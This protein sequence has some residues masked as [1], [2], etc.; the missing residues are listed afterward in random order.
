MTRNGGSTREWTLTAN[1]SPLI[2]VLLILFMVIAPASSRGETALVPQQ[3]NGLRGDRVALEVLRGSDGAT[4]L[5][6]NHQQV[7]EATDLS[8]ATGVGRIG[9]STPNV[10]ARR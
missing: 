4:P 1:V 8:H 5:A 6:I 2:D 7:A 9:L 10:Q 3:A